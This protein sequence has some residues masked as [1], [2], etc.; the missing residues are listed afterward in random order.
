MQSARQF[1]LVAE[2]VLGAG[3]DRQ[4]AIGPFGEGDARFHRS[5]LRIS[6]VVGLTQGFVRFANFF[7]ER[8]RGH[9]ALGVFSQIG[10]QVL[11]R[12]MGRR[13]PFR[14]FGDGVQGL[15]SGEIGRRS[16]PYKW[17]VLQRQHVLHGFR[18]FEINRNQL[19]PV[20]GRA[21][22]FAIH[23]PGTDHIG[24]KL[25]RPR[26]Q[27]AAIRTRDGSAENLP[28]LDR[29]Q[30]HVGWWG[31]SESFGQFVTLGELCIG[32]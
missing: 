31:L 28:L 27:I 26:H 14:C 17:P 20:G 23:H 4:L 11:A 21:Q 5:V 1:S 3:P 2:R 25:M 9:T 8:I 29:R 15:A 10:E 24:R 18:R 6:D 30:S 22:D 12:W 7:S 16:Q 19:C 32:N 13:L